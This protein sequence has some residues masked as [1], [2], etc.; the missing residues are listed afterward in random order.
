MARDEN[1]MPPIVEFAAE[2]TREGGWESEGEHGKEQANIVAIHE[3]VRQVTTWSYGRKTKCSF[4]FLH[5]RFA[6]NTKVLPTVN[7]IVSQ[8]S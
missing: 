8:S 6:K 2:T 5:P 4:R 7:Q 3:G 1:V